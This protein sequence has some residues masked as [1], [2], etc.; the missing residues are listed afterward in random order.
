MI[1]RINFVWW[2][3]SFLD[4]IVKLDAFIFYGDDLYTNKSRINTFEPVYKKRVNSN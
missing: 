2:V 1:G 3:I 4:L